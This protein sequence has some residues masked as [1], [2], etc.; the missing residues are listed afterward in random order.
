MNVLDLCTGYGGFS[1]ALRLLGGADRSPLRID[2]LRILSSGL[3]PSP[4]SRLVPSNYCS[5]D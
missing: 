5:T 4:G 1:L 3:T 2:Q